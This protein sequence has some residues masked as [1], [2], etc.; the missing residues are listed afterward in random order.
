M[1]FIKFAKRHRSELVRE[2]RGAVIEN[3]DCGTTAE[4]PKGPLD[5]LLVVEVATV[6]MGPFAGRQ[7]AKLGAEVIKVE[8]PSGDV[9]RRSGRFEYPGMP[10]TALSLGDGKRN[11][12]LDL[13]DA[14]DL[15]TLGRL[16]AVADVVL[17][18]YRPRQRERFGLSWETISEI[19]PRCVLIT[20][21]GY[22]SASER[23]NIP[24][25]DDTI[26]AAS[27]VCDVYRRL[28]GEPRYPP[29]VLADKVCGLS[30]IYAGLAA[31][32]RCQ[33]TG[34]GQWVDVP[35]F[36]VMTDFNLIEQLSDF[37][38][39]PPL[40][41][42]GWHRTLHPARRPHPTKDG[43]VCIL[44]Y[45]D[46]SW[47]R[48]LLLTSGE[49]CDSLFPTHRNRNDN[50]AQVQSII[51][52]FACTRTTDEVIADCSARGIPV[53]SVNSIED[54]VEDEYLRRR[55]TVERFEHPNVGAIWRTT[56]NFGYSESPLVSPLP[57]AEPGRDQEE[58]MCLIV[59]R[60]RT[61]EN[62]T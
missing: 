57:A 31:V 15:S 5:G 30:M 43:W 62:R 14:A 47:R 53:Q 21:Q 50:V 60:E 44:P 40:G 6:I 4:T 17:T 26:E 35:M 48:F 49:E 54:L 34:Q 25:Y 42:A 13:T 18:N 38:F 19:N 1:R 51:A 24:A 55:G 36:D 39:D 56:P 27:G 7:L 8:A 59:N 32:Y 41:D 20:A 58:V 10:G 11:I 61:R 46:E 22:A 12:V 33:I 9:L 2:I 29:Y 45:T 28:E 37:T 52:D 3:S 23:G 16:T